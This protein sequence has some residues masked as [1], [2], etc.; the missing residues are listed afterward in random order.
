VYGDPQFG[1]TIYEVRIWNGVV[2]QR[3]IA[4]STLLGPSVLPTNLTPTSATITVATTNMAGES[5]QQATVTVQLT[6]TGTN[7]LMANNDVTNWSSSATNVLTVSSSGLITAVGGGSATISATIGGIIASV[8][9]TVP[10]AAPKITQ[11]PPASAN[12]L[13]GGTLHASLVNIGIEPYFYHWYFNTNA[14]PISGA[15][16]AT[17]TIP[18]VQSADAG[19]YTCVISNAYGSVT[20]TPTVLAVIA[21]TPYQVSLLA[22]NPLAYWPLNETSGTVAYDMAGGYNGTYVGNVSLAQS[23]PTNATFGTS[24]YGVAFDGTTAYV[25]IPE[26]PFNITGPLT[27]MAWVQL[28]AYPNFAGLFGHGDT[29]WRMSVNP[30]GEPGANDG[31]LGSADATSSTS[32]VDGNWHFVA[33]TYSG[34]LSGQNGVLYVDGARVA[35]DAIAE[36]P[37]GNDLDVWIGGAPDYAAARLLAATIADAAIFT[38][39]LSAAEVAA[40]YSAQPIIGVERSGSSLVLTWSSGSL[41]QAPTLNGPWTTNTTAVPPYTVTVSGGNQFYKIQVP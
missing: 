16:T 37:P 4:A 9:I 12:I 29:S 5:S 33:Y 17:L 36:T 22:L 15:T 20:S 2:S 35:T 39:A 28:S 10:L 11:E 23:G 38:E 34:T 30:S 40:L 24:S 18:D 13:A 14:Q 3:Y 32:I 7:E 1:G 26:G 31:N 25:D 41:L 8:S 21:P 19:S 6:Q 27:T